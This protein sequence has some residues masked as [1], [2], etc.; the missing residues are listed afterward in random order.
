MKG[1]SLRIFLACCLLLWAIDM[2][3]PW[4]K[5]MRSEDNLFSSIQKREQLVVGTINNAFSY[6]V[7]SNGAAGLEYEL[8]KAFADYDLTPKS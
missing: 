6:F 2:V 5:I 3:F 1:L 8:T 4:Q 7:S